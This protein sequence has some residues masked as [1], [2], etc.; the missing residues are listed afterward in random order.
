MIMTS[1]LSVNCNL[2]RHQIVCVGLKRRQLVWCNVDT[3]KKT[4]T[5]TKTWIET[6]IETKASTAV[7]HNISTST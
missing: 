4:T 1:K 7:I 3:F 5:T 2:R 6:V